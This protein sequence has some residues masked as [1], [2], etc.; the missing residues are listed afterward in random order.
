LLLRIE[1]IIVLHGSKEE[2]I[3]DDVEAGFPRKKKVKEEV[4]TTSKA[5]VFCSF[6]TNVVD[7]LVVDLC[8][9][10]DL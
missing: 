5:D 8:S 9:D 7:G 2:D 4:K 1:D 6:Q 3:V 10:T